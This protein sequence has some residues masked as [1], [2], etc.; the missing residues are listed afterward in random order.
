MRRQVRRGRHEAPVMS[1]A[2]LH[3]ELRVAGLD[4]L[5]QEHADRLETQNGV[6][7]DV[8]RV[9]SAVGVAQEGESGSP[10]RRGVPSPARYVVTQV[11]GDELDGE[12]GH[13]P[14]PGHRPGRVPVDDAGHFG[15]VEHHVP[16]GQIT[17]PDDLQVADLRVPIIAASWDDAVSW[18]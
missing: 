4:V 17:V 12:V 8:L 7:D 11:E 10:V 18:G 15:A 9:E 5:P 14:G 3:L 1:F 2:T 13:V 16:R 6:V